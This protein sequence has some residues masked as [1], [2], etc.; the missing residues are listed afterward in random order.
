MKQIGKNRYLVGNANLSPPDIYQLTDEFWIGNWFL[1][2]S[3]VL[4]KLEVNKLI[5]YQSV[6][7]RGSQISTLVLLWWLI[8][9]PFWKRLFFR[10]VEKKGNC[11]EFEKMSNKFFACL[12]VGFILMSLV[13]ITQYTYTPIK[14]KPIK[15][16]LTWNL[17]F[18]KI[19]LWL[20]NYCSCL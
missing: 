11:C 9:Y 5:I 4:S 16:C 15:Y 8:T 1:F 18:Q 19:T 20:F 6:Y 3:W 12:A 7:S 13:L 14:F 2:L 17:F 10:C